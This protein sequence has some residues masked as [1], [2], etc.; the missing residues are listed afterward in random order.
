[1]AL[2]VPNYKY[3]LTCKDERLTSGPFTLIQASYWKNYCN[4]KFP[5]CGP[6]KVILW[7]D[8]RNARKKKE[9]TSRITGKR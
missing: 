8:R 5:D 4:T 6:H 9:R 2:T 3:G 1:M 7:K